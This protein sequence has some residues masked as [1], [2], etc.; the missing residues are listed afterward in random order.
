MKSIVPEI[1][2]SVASVINL[3]ILLFAVYVSHRSNCIASQMLELSKSIDQATTEQRNK[4]NKL[5]WALVFSGVLTIENRNI[6]KDRLGFILKIFGWESVLSESNIRASDL[7][8]AANASCD[9]FFDDAMSQA[10][11]IAPK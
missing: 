11:S 10:D 5:F 3:L 9:K 2:L 4:S 1:I 7:Q 6:R 8:A